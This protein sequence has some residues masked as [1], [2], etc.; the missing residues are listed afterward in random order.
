M[1]EQL[2]HESE[3]VRRRAGLSEAKRQ[4]LARQL[5]RKAGELGTAVAGIPRRPDRGSAPLSFSQQ[6]LWFLDQLEGGSAAY[7][8]PSSVRL[9]GRLDGGALARSLDAVARRH[10]TLRTT[11]ANR[12]GRP[13]QVIA[14]EPGLRLPLIDLGPLPAAAREAQARRLAAAE[15]RRGFDLARGPLVRMTLLRLAAEDHVVLLTMHH[16]VSDGWSMGLLIRE[17]GEGYAALCRRRPAALA[18]LPI[19]YADFAHWQRQWLQGEVLDNELAFWR[20]R[21]RGAPPELALPMRP[22]AAGLPPSGRLQPLSLPH[23]L[24]AAAR[25]R[26]QAAGATPFMVLLAALAVLL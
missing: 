24:A 14:P 5:R 15:R 17:L 18:E 1:S 12:E 25:M 3:L 13:E 7:N 4:L 8:C 21:L 6:R 22:P 9:R 26:G 20:H 16:M 10:E 11:F 2:R 23:R 19:Q